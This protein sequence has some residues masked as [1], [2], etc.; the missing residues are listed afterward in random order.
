MTQLPVHTATRYVQPLREG[1]SLPAVIDTSDAGM[2][3]AKF[4]GAGQ[5]VKVLIAEIIVALLAA[6][7]G[8]PT[9]EIALI[10]VLDAFGRS[11]PDPEIQDL[12]RA[13]HGLNFGARYL[14]GAFNF[15]SNAAQDFVAPDLAAR[16]VWLD[17]YVTNPDRTHRNPNLMVYGRKPYLI[18]HGAALYAQH[19]WASVDEARTRAAFPL[20]KD[21]MLL[22]R[23]DDIRAADEE[24]APRFT[25]EVIARVLNA[26]P[27]DFLS[28]AALSSDF[29]SPDAARNRYAEYLIARVTSPRAFVDE[30]IAAKDRGANTPPRRVMSRR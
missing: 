4:R 26:V 20:I 16:I 17:A 14:D 6:E 9:P 11:E 3:V 5:G 21:H 18:D 29:D 28:S 15:D 13:S 23:S 1:G 30:A 24:L 2:F 8:L 22:A 19:D 7:A 25:P 10:E 12:L 27:D